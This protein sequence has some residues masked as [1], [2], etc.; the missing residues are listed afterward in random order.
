M[1][2]FAG[3]YWRRHERKAARHAQMQ[4]H[5]SAALELEDQ[6][7]GATLQGSHAQ[8]DQTIWRASQGPAQGLSHAHTLRESPYQRGGKAA[9]GCF[10]FG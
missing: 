3:R 5:S 6:V 7:L 2:V 4:Q 9:T 8:P 1:I 10:D